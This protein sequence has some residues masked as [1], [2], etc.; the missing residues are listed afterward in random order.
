MIE[1]SKQKSITPGITLK[2]PTL[3]KPEIVIT[4]LK[5][6]TPSTSKVEKYNFDKFLMNKESS[7]ILDKYGYELPSSYKEHKDEEDY[8]ID[9]TIA[10]INEVIKDDLK[11]NS[12]NTNFF[13][14]SCLLNKA[15]ILLSIGELCL[16]GKIQCTHHTGKIWL[17]F[18]KPF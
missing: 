13:Y 14:A 1:T 5:E 6:A 12:G 17:C 2:A 15:T 18:T 16:R 4:P 8:N 3:E 9:K 11:L 10:D 7:D